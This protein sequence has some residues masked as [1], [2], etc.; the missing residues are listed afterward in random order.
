MNKKLAKI[1]EASLNIQDRGILTFWLHVD[2]EEGC[3]QGVGGIAL[4]DWDED[5]RGRKGTAFGCEVIRQ[6]LLCMGVD[7]FSK[8]RGKMIWVLGEGEGLSFTPRGIQ[9]LRVDNASQPKVVWSE[10][11][12]SMGVVWQ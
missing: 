5:E 1:R 3:S 12:E 7:D 11:A 10:I 8:M 4:D 6:I 2:Y 9:A